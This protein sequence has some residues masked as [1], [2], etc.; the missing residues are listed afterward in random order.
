MIQCLKHIFCT[1]SGVIA[2]TSRESATKKAKGG[3]CCTSAP[4]ASLSE[5]FTLLSSTEVV[6]R[7][8]GCMLWPWKLHRSPTCCTE[9]DVLH[10]LCIQIAMLVSSAASQEVTIW[11]SGSSSKACPYS[12]PRTPCEPLA[13]AE[14]LTMP[15]P[16]LG[17]GFR[18]VRSNRLQARFKRYSGISNA[19]R[20]LQCLLSY[21]NST[22]GALCAWR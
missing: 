10:Y 17:K 6:I 15:L 20:V 14:L 18:S 12:C 5:G 7:T 16:N 2:A 1:I 3:T 13:P 9:G 4:A 21:Y 8:A 11:V 19:R 22:C